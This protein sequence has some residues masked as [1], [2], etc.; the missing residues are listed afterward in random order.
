MTSSQKRQDLSDHESRVVGALLGVHAGDS[1]GATVEFAPHDL[2]AQDHPGGL[3]EI[4]GG[5]LLSWPAG[6]ATDDTDMTRG[7]LL[8]YRDLLPGQDIARIAAEY[9][10]K[11]QS[12]DWPG[13]EPGS[14]PKDIGI[15]V[16]DG[17]EL[18]SEVQDPDRSGAGKGRAGNG[19]LMRCIPTGLFQTDPDTLII[20]SE[21]ISRVTHNDKRCTVSCAAY[22]TIVSKLVTENSPADAIAA[23]Q[24]VATTLKSAQ[25]KSAIEL[26]K[27]LSIA[28]MAKKGPSSK[29]KDEG[30]GYV[31]DSLSI[32]IAA[33]LDKRSLENVVVDV[34]RIGG[35]TDTNAAIAG[36]LLGARDGE[37]AIPLRWKTKLQFADE[38][39]RV[40]LS[41]LRK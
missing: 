30:A 24:E 1:L 4:I 9:F 13:R 6:H 2:I 33:L 11:W 28:T 17:L 18:Y 12:G 14:D 41:L 40:A 27:S 22:N 29:L 21:R 25:V 5:G 36:G 19:S 3:R 37:A 8:A 23:G 26:G 31:L 16:A 10:L 34:V 38:F 7:V 20:E 15:A 35:D 32:A 39:E